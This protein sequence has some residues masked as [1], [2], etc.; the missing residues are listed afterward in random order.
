M[1]KDLSKKNAI[2]SKRLRDNGL[3]DSI[4]VNENINDLAIVI[5]RTQVFRGLFY[6][7]IEKR[8]F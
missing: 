2:L 3:D 5:K 6:C 4:L 8:L 7:K 1:V